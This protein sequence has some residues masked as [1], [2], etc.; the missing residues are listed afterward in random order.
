MHQLSWAKWPYVAAR[1]DPLAFHATDV[2]SILFKN[3]KWV[4][5]WTQAV[6]SVSSSHTTSYPATKMFIKRNNS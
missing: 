4:S 6:V 3:G 2:H 5:V 1:T